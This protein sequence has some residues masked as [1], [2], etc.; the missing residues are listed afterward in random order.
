MER[1]IGAFE[2]EGL[3]LQVVHIYSN[4]GC[5]LHLGS[6]AVGH[7]QHCWTQHLDHDELQNASSVKSSSPHTVVILE[8]GHVQDNAMVGEVDDD[9]QGSKSNALRYRARGHYS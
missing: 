2:R 9:I 6:S 4:H 5:L 8:G 3:V 7:A 1:Y